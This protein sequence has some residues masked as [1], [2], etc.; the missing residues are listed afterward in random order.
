[1]LSG[2]PA[3][4]R[5]RS[6]AGA[7]GAAET[8]ALRAAAARVGGRA[9]AAAVRRRRA[10]A[11]GS[12]AR[13]CT[14]TRRPTAPAARSPPST[15]TCS[16]TPSAGRAR[17]AGARPLTDALVGYLRS[18]RR[19]GPH[20]RARRA[21]SLSR[22]RPRHRRRR[23]PA[24]SSVAGA[25][26]DRRRHAARA[27]RRWRA[28][29]CRRLVPRAAASRYR[30]RAGDAEGR[31]GARRPDPVGRRRRSRGA[32]HRAR[33]RRR[34]RVPGLGRRGA[35]RACPSARSCCSASRSVADPTR[36]PAGKHT[37]WAYTHGPQPGR[38]LGRASRTR[39][40]E[41]MEAQVER[42]APGFR[43]R[44][45]ARHVLGPADLQARNANL[46]GGDVGGGSYRLRQ[47]VFRPLPTLSPYRTP[48][49][50]PVPGQR[51]DV[52]GRRRPRR[53]RRRRGA[54]GVGQAVVDHLG[55]RPPDRL[56]RRAF[57]G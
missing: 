23:S 15:S 16:A 47:V 22:G 12:T 37:A 4:R 5:R 3:G 53:A 34:G 17:A 1:M 27:G 39:H 20:R 28:T 25:D 6:A 43:D 40:V 41:R 7:R 36:A 54:R 8:L 26:R 18:A 2:F 55:R 38:R 45:L 44:I 48:L 52:P 14:A 46:V 29:R 42:F 49:R 30:L 32:G 31:L 21:A 13:R 33:R 51:G 50:G 19:R 9:G 57:R 11:R 10:R 56:A 35:R 24:A